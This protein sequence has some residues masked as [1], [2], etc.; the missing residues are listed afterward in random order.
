MR[1]AINREQLAWA[2]GLFEGE[3][4]FVLGKVAHL[5]NVRAILCST[6]RDVL[7]RFG[8]VMGFG[9]IHFRKNYKGHLGKKQVIQ[10]STGSFELTQATMALL[11]PWLGKRRRAKIIESLREMRAYHAG[12][13]PQRGVP[14]KRR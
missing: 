7:A 4:S 2:G 11:W 9:N 8:R 14:R 13:G 6:D 10:W 3:G 12:G 5:R 1:I